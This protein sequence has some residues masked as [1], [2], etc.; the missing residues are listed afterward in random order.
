MRNVATLDSETMTTVAVIK[1]VGDDVKMSHCC[2]EVSEYTARLYGASYDRETKVFTDE[3]GA[4][5]PVA[6]IG[7]GV[8]A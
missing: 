6:V 4:V 3:K 7:G 1:C 5:I 8:D 2:I